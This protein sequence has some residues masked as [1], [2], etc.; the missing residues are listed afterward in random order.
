MADTSEPDQYWFN[1][2]TNQVEIGK[3]SA[4]IYRVGPFNTP[5]EAA[6]ALSILKRRSE[7]WVEDEKASD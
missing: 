3:L 1:L 4:A 2:K 7:A 5:T 6:E